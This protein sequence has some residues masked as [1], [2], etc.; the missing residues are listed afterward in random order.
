M[1]SVDV[2]PLSEIETMGVITLHPGV[3]LQGE[4]SLLDSALS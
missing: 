4:A 1:V 3:E 2:H